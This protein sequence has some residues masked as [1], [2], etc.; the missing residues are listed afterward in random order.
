MS[1]KKMLQSQ[2]KKTRTFEERILQVLFTAIAKADVIL[3]SAISTH[4]QSY[5]QGKKPQEE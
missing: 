2:L 1:Q 3:G 4:E 5:K